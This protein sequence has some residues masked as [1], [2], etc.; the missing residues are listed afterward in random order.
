[1]AAFQTHCT[2]ISFLPVHILSQGSLFKYIMHRKVCIYSAN[3]F[4]ISRVISI[5]QSNLLFC[6]SNKTELRIS[7]VNKLIQ[8]ISTVLCFKWLCINWAY[9][10]KEIPNGKALDCPTL[11]HK[12]LLQISYPQRIY[13][14]NLNLNV[15]ELRFPH[16]HTPSF[17]F[18]LPSNKNLPCESHN[19]QS[20]RNLVGSVWIVNPLP[21]VF[22]IDTPTTFNF[23]PLICHINT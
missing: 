4:L 21:L 2:E 6:F 16:T 22:A 5:W 18:F 8:K 20:S 9:I 14:A 13:T 7:L 17:F 19:F 1:M 12:I 10:S 11:G 3:T 23:V 15:S